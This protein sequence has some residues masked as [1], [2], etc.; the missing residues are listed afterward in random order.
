MLN[1][2]KQQRKQ[3]WSDLIVATDM[4]HGANVLAP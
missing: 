2:K 4:C 1:K 3:E